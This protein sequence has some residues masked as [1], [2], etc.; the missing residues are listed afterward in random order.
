MKINARILSEAQELS[1]HLSDIGNAKRSTG[2]S[3]L[4]TDLWRL[5]EAG[6]KIRR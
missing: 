4:R 3:R 2:E 1:A 5:E 6:E